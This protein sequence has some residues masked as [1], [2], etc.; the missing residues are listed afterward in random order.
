MSDLQWISVFLLVLLNFVVSLASTD[1]V[2]AKID[3]PFKRRT[4]EKCAVSFK[5]IFVVWH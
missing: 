4:K 2:Q 1:D 3:L 5:I